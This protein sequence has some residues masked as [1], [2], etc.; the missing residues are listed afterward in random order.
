LSA[1]GSKNTSEK[2]Y[3]IGVDST[4][5]PFESQNSEG[6]YVGIDIDIF[7]AIA[8]LENIKYEMSYPGF[9]KQPR[10][11]H[12]DDDLMGACVECP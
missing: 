7:D 5:A 8:K 9:V 2:V 11:A 6:K 3:K 4:F 12:S 10:M 1:C